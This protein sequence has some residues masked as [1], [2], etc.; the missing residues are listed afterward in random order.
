MAT[1]NAAMTELASNYSDPVTVTI[2]FKN[3]KSG[4]GASLTSYTSATYVDFLTALKA[5]ATTA[6]DTLALAKLPVQTNNPV[7]GDPTISLTLS[8]ARTLGFSANT[9]P[10]ETD[11]TISL[12]ISLMNISPSDADPSKYSL[13]ETTLHELTEVLGSSSALDSGTTG[14]VNPIDLFRYDDKGNRS[15]TQ[16]PNASAFFSLNGTTMLAQFNQDKS[17]DFGDYFS[18]N[19]NQKPQI[20]DAFGS[21]GASNVPLGA[22]LV[23]LDVVG[24]NRGAAITNG[25]GGGGVPTPL[26]PVITSPATCNPNPAYVGG[27][28]AFSVAASDP[29]NSPITV[30]WDFGD[31]TKG[32]DIS[33]SHRFATAGMYTV[34]ATVVDGLGLSTTSSVVV[35]VSLTIKKA[36]SLKQSFTLNFKFPNNDGGTSGGKDRLDITLQ[37]DDFTN[38]ADGT[39]INIAI[40]NNI[41][42]SGTLFKNKAVG[43]FGKFT[44]N[45]RSGTLRYTTTKAGLQFALNAFGAVNDDADANLLIPIAI[46]FN[47][48]IYGDT[49]SFSYFSTAGKMGKGK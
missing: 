2:T 31:G 5:H 24:Y 44:L 19:G 11:S 9:N 36:D 46:T 43:D 15:Y 4:L 6:N 32:A 14:P 30:S 48:G 26:P 42:D 27:M 17:G 38:V 13:R 33:G 28:C 7:N 40:G 49:Y 20:Q 25:T 1:I 22:E 35:D 10:G 37:N 18:I 21:P 29:N 8:N 3:V 23:T 45:V 16:D 12:N 34:V 41:I 39:D 47:G